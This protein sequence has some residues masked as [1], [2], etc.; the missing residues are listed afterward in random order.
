MT[1]KGRGLL[2]ST[3]LL[4]SAH[5]WFSLLLLEHTDLL[6]LLPRTRPVVN[7]NIV[8]IGKTSIPVYHSYHSITAIP[9]VSRA[10]PTLDTERNC[11]YVDKL[12]KLEAAKT[13][14]SAVSDQVRG[15]Q[16]LVMFIFN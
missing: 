16:P 13:A 3:R 10:M 6:L 11:C 2:L 5:I 15:L 4:A 12:K 8:P 14:N 7:T 9:R 1:Q